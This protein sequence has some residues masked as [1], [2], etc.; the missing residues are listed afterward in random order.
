MVKNK[1]F[2]MEC[3][4]AG[5]QYHDI[6]EVFNKLEV[7]T[8]L[9]LVRELDNR[10]DQNAVAVVYENELGNNEVEDVL[11]GYIPRS[12]NSDL[13]SFLE[14]GWGEMFECRICRIKPDAHYEQQIHLSIK[15][16]RN[17]RD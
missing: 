11:I 14:M 6:I 4:L 13:A 3:H 9:K 2:Y 15:I 16:K 17:R 5:T 10:F 8:H 1:L 7:G 12:D